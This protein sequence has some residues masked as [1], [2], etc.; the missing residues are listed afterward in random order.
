MRV[1]H[2]ES[3]PR[4][5]TK[6]SLVARDFACARIFCAPRRR[7]SSAWCSDRPRAGQSSS[8]RNPV[9][10][11]LSFAIT[12]TGLLGDRLS[13]GLVAATE[14][15]VCK[16]L[17]RHLESLP[18]DDDRSR[19]VVHQ[20]HADEARHGTHALESG[21]ADFPAPVK[22]LMTLVSRVMTESSYR[23]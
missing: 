4:L 3:A 21:G 6:V 1:N 9:W 22:A 20:M 10:Y 7:R 14:E 5:S 11:G 15:Q 23:I 18:A 12:A 8:A 16:H 13:L 19:A 17:E 2:G